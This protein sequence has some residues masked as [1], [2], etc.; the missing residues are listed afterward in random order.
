RPKARTSNFTRGG[1]IIFHNI[2]MYFQVIGAIF[3]WYFLAIAIIAGL[4][5]Y[6]FID[7]ET[8]KATQYHWKVWSI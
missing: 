2:R 1:Q 5:I 7:A 3:H 4:A 8:L 6:S